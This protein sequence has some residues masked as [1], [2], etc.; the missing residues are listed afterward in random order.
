MNKIVLKPK[1]QKN[2][3]Y[4]AHLQMKNYI[5]MIVHLKYMKVLETIFSLYVKIV[6]L[7]MLETTK[8]LKTIGKILLLKQ[9]KS[10]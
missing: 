4:I 5:T 2:L 10:L 1:S 9:L 3:V 6:F 8:R 7:L